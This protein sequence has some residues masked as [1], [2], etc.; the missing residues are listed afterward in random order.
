MFT[1]YSGASIPVHK[2]VKYLTNVSQ[3]F[4][5]LFY[6]KLIKMSLFLYSMKIHT[7]KPYNIIK[8]VLKVMRAVCF[9]LF[10]V[11][12]LPLQSKD[13]NELLKPSHSRP[14]PL[15]PTLG[16]GFA[17]SFVML[18]MT[19]KAVCNYKCISHY[20]VFFS[21][22]D[23]KSLPTL[24]RIPGLKLSGQAFA[25]TLMVFEFLHNFGET[26]GFG[27]C[28]CRQESMLVLII[29]CKLCMWLKFSHP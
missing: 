1:L 16:T 6:K 5:T 23:H 20:T 19:L 18:S 21:F 26:L 24:N 2:P 9:W 4:V 3:S 29:N 8:S 25:D 27:G 13:T 17:I 7:N 22:T 10:V 12:V 11:W 14:C 15:P 28:S